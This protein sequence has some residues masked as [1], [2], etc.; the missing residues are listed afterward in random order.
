M[1][2]KKNL[3]TAENF[4]NWLDTLSVDEGLPIIS[5]LVM[6]FCDTFEEREQLRDDIIEN[7]ESIEFLPRG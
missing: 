3:K 7:L 5:S 6:Q 2:N 1:T 4:S